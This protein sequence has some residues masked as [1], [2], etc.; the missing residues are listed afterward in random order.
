MA[1]C[2]PRV[3]EAIARDWSDISIATASIDNGRAKTD[4][5]VRQVDIPLG[6]LEELIEWRQRR[7]E[8]EGQGER[9]FVTHPSNGPVSRQTARNVQAQLKR[10][11][12]RANERLVE[13]GIEPI[14]ERVTPHS[15]RR[16]YASVRAACGD[17]PG[18]HR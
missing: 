18:L 5:G 6:P 15:L 10:A 17:D 9:T 8:Y 7:P 14:S 11:I 13:L 16:I 2:G 12:K 4:A 3:G 1:G